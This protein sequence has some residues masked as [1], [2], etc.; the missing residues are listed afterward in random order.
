MTAV[1]RRSTA[2]LVTPVAAP[3]APGD[4]HPA[5]ACFATVLQ[6]V[7][8][9]VEV[10]DEDPVQRARPVVPSPQNHGPLIVDGIVFPAPLPR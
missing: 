7:S 2:P 8:Q 3:A 9:D 5:G 4:H 1:R 10:A 6:L